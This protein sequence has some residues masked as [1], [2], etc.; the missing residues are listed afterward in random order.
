MDQVNPSLA[1]CEDPPDQSDKSA[2]YQLDLAAQPKKKKD[3]AALRTASSKDTVGSIFIA[4]LGYITFARF[5]MIEDGGSVIRVIF[6]ESV[7]SAADDA[8]TSWQLSE[9]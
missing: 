5:L 1:C 7:R 6:R 3:A 2:E 9:S 8:Q 4:E